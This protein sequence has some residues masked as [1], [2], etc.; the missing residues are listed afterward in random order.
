M[1]RQ[2]GRSYLSHE[3]TGVVVCRKTLAVTIGPWLDEH[4]HDANHMA[5]PC[6]SRLIKPGHFGLAP[7]AVLSNNY[8]QQLKS[9]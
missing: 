1:Q 6:K 3:L 9:Q 8:Q 5:W 4:R 2:S 7:E